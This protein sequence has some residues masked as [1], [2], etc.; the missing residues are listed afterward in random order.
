MTGARIVLAIAACALVGCSSSLGGS[1]GSPPAK[2]YIILPNGHEVP[3]STQTP[4]PD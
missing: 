3:A 1:G 2:T 4:P